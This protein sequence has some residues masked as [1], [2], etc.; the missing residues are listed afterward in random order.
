MAD[1]GPQHAN[2]L[3]ENVFLV[4]GAPRDIDGIPALHHP[5]APPSPN[6]RPIPV[7]A[8]VQQNAMVSN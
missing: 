4:G 6:L 5:L 3:Q 8:G 2:P 7:H 1:V